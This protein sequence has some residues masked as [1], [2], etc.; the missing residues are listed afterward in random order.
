MSAK[1]PPIVDIVDIEPVCIDPS[2]GL[3]GLAGDPDE[4]IADEVGNMLSQQGIQIGIELGFKPDDEGMFTEAEEQ[5]L[6][7]ECRRRVIARLAQAA[8]VDTP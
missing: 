2:W 1:F 5:A 7:D 6:I 4:D 3:E 8:A